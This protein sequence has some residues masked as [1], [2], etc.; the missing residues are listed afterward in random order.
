MDSLANFNEET[1][2]N[3]RIVVDWLDGRKA[4]DVFIERALPAY[5]HN[6]TIS[7]LARRIG[8]IWRKADLSPLPLRYFLNFFPN[9]NPKLVTQERER[10]SK[11]GR[12]IASIYKQKEA[13]TE[14]GL[15]VPESLCDA[16]TKQVRFQAERFEIDADLL[17]RRSPDIED[18][19]SA[20]WRVAHDRDKG[21]A[22]LVFIMFL[23]E[24]LERVKAMQSFKIVNVQH[25]DYKSELFNGKIL[26]LE[27]L[28]NN[29]E[30]YPVLAV[31]RFT[32]QQLGLVCPSTPVSPGAIMTLQIFRAVKN[33]KPLSY[34]QATRPPD[35][36]LE[37]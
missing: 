23:P 26:T 14:K 28:P 19:V 12:A 1:Q 8:A 24:I 6:D 30:K 3:E 34:V 31:E 5:S 2:K 35:E 7:Q 32:R 20:M 4:K 17:R 15:E 29:D 16:I 13:Y 36:L 25:L 27:F 18:R 21:R 33:D 9:P 37:F 10:L 11:W 22:S